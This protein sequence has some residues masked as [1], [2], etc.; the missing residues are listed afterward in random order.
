MVLPLEFFAVI[1]YAST[2][3]SLGLIPRSSASICFLILPRLR[4]SVCS[5]INIWGSTRG[6]LF[7]PNHCHLCNRHLTLCCLRCSFAFFVFVCSLKKSN[8]AAKIKCACKKGYL[9]FNSQCDIK[10]SSV[11][12]GINLPKGWSLC[13][14]NYNIFKTS[15]SN[16]KN[17]FTIDDKS[18]MFEMFLSN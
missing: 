2:V 12:R 8:V 13:W 16:I 18:E 4:R 7:E 10:Y 6:G 15:L 14:W 1:A 11:K 9:Y 5:H 17:I 3:I